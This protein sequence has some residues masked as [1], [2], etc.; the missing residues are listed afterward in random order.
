MSKK[1]T[2]DQSIIKAYPSKDLFISILTRDVTIRDAIGDLLD[3]SVDGALRLRPDRNYEGLFVHIEI[4]AENEIFKIEDNCGGLP[5]DE[6]RENAFRFGRLAGFEGTEGSVGVFGIG[7]KRALFRLGNN[8]I[9]KSTAVNSSFSMQ[10]D[11][12]NWKNDENDD[13]ASSSWQFNFDEGYIENRKEEFSLEERGTTI[14]VSELHT[15]VLETFRMKSEISKLRFELKREHLNSIDKGLEIKVNGVTLD[16]TELELIF[17]KDF[18]TAYWEELDGKVKAKIYAGIS[19]KEEHG[20][21]GGWYVFCNDRL[22]IGPD[23]T[24]AT[25][26]GVKTPIRIPHYHPQYYRF[27][28]Y[29]FLEAQDP[30]DLPWNTAKTGLDKDHPVYRTVL[31]KMI[32]MMRTVINFLNQVHREQRAYRGDKILNT[33][34]QDA[35]DS[36][37]IARLSKVVK[38]PDNITLDRFIAPEPAKVGKPSPTIVVI[39]YSVLESRFLLVKD[40]WEQSE[41]ETDMKT[42]KPKEIGEMVFNYFYEREIE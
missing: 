37:K 9:V 22:V 16:S 41:T 42:L 8:F 28:G 7:M 10:V 30:T 1:K 31:L 3:N 13:D 23:Q 35:I 11:V 18:K 27:R 24:Q 2:N 19:E 21:N 39:K 6:A 40:Y 29:V 14:V 20:D 38:D 25:G 32:Q 34:S 12:E 5:I 15:G 33:P 4:D 36:A 26:W 17:S